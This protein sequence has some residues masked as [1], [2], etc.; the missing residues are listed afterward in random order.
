M[1]YRI[2]S[3]EHLT[4]SLALWVSASLLQ[5]MNYSMY[6][7]SVLTLNCT[8]Q[9]SLWN[10]G[11]AFLLFC[12]LPFNT[13]YPELHSVT[14]Q[15][16]NGPCVIPTVCRRDVWVQLRSNARHDNEAARVWAALADRGLEDENDRKRPKVN[17]TET[18]TVA[19][20]IPQVSNVV[21]SSNKMEAV[22]SG[23]IVCTTD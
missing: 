6:Q 8:G 18:R 11:S 12:C 15:P 16:Q 19:E 17:E 2:A 10:E 3:I 20:S 22:H 23:E 13:L 14:W 4:C 9:P 7:I 21:L 1:C 5:Q